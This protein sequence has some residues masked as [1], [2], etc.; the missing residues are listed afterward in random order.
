[1]SYSYYYPPYPTTGYIPPA[2]DLRYVYHRQSRNPFKRRASYVQPVQYMYA[3]TEATTTAPV[4][5]TSA[6]PAYASTVYR[7]PAATAVAYNVPAATT[8][9]AYTVPAA[10]T[11]TTA[12]VTTP[13]TYTTRSY[14]PVTRTVYGDSFMSE[15]YANAPAQYTAMEPRTSYYGY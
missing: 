11:T 12:A 4:Y 10:T 3:P 1:M 5:Y 13:V 7:A 9:A 6:A 8:T 2:E 15:Y 14:A